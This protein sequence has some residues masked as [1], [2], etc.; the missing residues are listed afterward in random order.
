MDASAL[1]REARRRSGLSQ[2]DLAARCGTSQA[3]IS[4]YESGRKTPS[5]ETLLRLVEEL[6]FE[7]ALHPRSVERGSQLPSA[8]ELARRSQTLRDVLELAAALPTRHAPRSSFPRIDRL[9]TR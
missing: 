2:S 5:S 8:R 4:A 1:L 6:G 3:T 9:A 7:L